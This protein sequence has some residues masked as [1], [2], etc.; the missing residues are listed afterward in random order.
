MTEPVAY[1]WKTERGTIIGFT[2]NDNS[3][4]VGQ[5]GIP[6]YTADQLHPR[7]KMTKKQHKQ[8][9]N[10]K[11]N[12]NDFYDFWQSLLVDDVSLFKEISE[13]NLMLAWLD[14][15][16]IEIVPDVKWFVRS[17]RASNF[18]NYIYLKK[19][20]SDDKVTAFNLKSVAEQFETKE[21]AELWTNPLTEAVQLPVEGE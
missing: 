7:V 21:E 18:G 2:P 14:D 6:L 16:T 4:A 13:R 12:K 9:E 3:H 1:M 15:E 19:I 8:F 17:K 5:L 10:Y 20:E 11:T